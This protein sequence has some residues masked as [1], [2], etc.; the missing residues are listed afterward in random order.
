MKLLIWIGGFFGAL[1]IAFVVLAFTS[2][3]AARNTLLFVGGMFVLSAVFNAALAFR[4]RSTMAAD[5]RLAETGKRADAVVEEVRATSMNVNLNPLV[6]L[7]LRVEP[8]G[9]APFEITR[10]MVVSRVAFPRA[11]DRVSICYDPANPKKFVFA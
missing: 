8:E 10:R 7:R 2:S 5:A 3:P 1:G 11:G 4:N 6:V 9:E